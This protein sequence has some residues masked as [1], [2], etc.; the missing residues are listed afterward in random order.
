MKAPAGVLKPVGCASMEALAG[1]KKIKRKKMTPG[2]RKKK[3]QFVL[4]EP[5]KCGGEEKKKRKT[6]VHMFCK[7]RPG[8]GEKKKEKVAYC[9]AYRGHLVL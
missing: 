1:K 4:Q 9:F 8:T 2:K 7:N 5:P 6:C 3:T